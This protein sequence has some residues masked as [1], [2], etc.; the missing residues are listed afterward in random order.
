MLRPRPARFEVE[1]KAQMAI[2]AQPP[3][4]HRMRVLHAMNLG[5]ASCFEDL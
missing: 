2:V 5:C 4:R 3:L 1:A